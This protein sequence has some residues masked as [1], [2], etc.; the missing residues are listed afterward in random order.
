VLTA[1][2]GLDTPLGCALRTDV[3]QDKC[4]L[5]NKPLYATGYALTGA[6]AVGIGFTLFWP[7]K[8]NSSAA[9]ET[10]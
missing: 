2:D 9:P 3:L 10:H 7:T 8:S 6:L 4:V 1:T 5:K